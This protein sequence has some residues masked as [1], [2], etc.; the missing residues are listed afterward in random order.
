MPT[1][2]LKTLVCAVTEDSITDEAYL[3]ANGQK[4]WGSVGMKAGESQS[5]NRQVN[6]VNLVEIK[7]FD[8][9]GPFDDNDYLGTITVTSVLKG[10]GVQT[11]KFT[12][13]GANYS[14]YYEVV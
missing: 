2:K 1:L 14:L 7:L 9:D 8:E 13:N 11:G 3:V 4:I 5:I 6:F 10:K 12:G